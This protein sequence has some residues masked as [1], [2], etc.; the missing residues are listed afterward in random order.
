MNFA[1][2]WVMVLLSLLM[3]PPMCDCCEDFVISSK[4]SPLTN[5][6]RRRENIW[7][8]V[9]WLPDKAY[10]IGGCG[11]GIYLMEYSDV[12]SAIYYYSP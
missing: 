5:R 8:A 10:F 12:L 7:V 1:G 6:E 2:V 4:F 3:G 9:E 11:L